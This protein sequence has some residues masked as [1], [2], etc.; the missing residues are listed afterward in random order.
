M[1][2]IRQRIKIQDIKKCEMKRREMLTT[3]GAISVGMATPSL[4]KGEILA[5][6]YKTQR[7]KLSADIVVIGGGTAG[8]IAAIQAGRAG[9]K[10]ILIEAGSQLGG[11]TTVGGVSFPGI[12]FAWGKQVI[13]GI[14]WELVQETVDLNDDTLP[15]F[16]IPHGRQHWRHQVRLN[17]HV[18]AMLAEEKALDAGVQ[19]RY[20]ESPQR[21]SFHNNRW[22]IESVG[23]GVHT[24]ITCNQLIDCSGNALPTAMAGYDVLRESEIQPGTLQFRIDGYDLDTLDKELIK[25]QYQQAIDEGRFTPEEFRSNIIGLLDSHGDNIQHVMGA[26]STTSESHTKANIDGRR[27]LLRHLRYLRTL[28]GCEK[29]TLTD[30]QTETATRETFR[31]DGHYQITHEDYVTGKLFE[32]AVSYSYYPIDLHDAKGVIP[33]HLEEGVVATIPL[34]ALVPKKSRNFIVAGRCLSSDRLAN[35][36]LRVQASCMGMGQAAGAAAVLANQKGS[37][38]LE[39]PF[40]ELRELIESHGGIVPA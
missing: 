8:T 17:G 14:G 31:I 29:T 33:D 40:D 13:G 30:M 6:P 2:W 16:S 24:T 3:M 36:A 26:D 22:E 38:P 23:K 9:C 28:P 12:F 15:N 34:R 37:T 20:Y 7:Q 39:V 10:T 1:L 19:L 35:S 27:S 11:T 32:D 5:A 4:S 18:Y 21:L 25:K